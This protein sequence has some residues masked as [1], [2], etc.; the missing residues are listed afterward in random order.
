M[1][2]H[3]NNHDEWDNSRTFLAFFI[4]RTAYMLFTLCLPNV[5]RAPCP[6]L[7]LSLSQS[8]SMSANV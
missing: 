2:A 4:L 5:E 7:S 8:L 6:S 1:R 3:T